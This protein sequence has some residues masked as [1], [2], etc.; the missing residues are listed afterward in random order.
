MTFGIEY[1][2]PGDWDAFCD[3]CKFKRKASELVKEWTGLM[4]CHDTCFEPRHP[5]ELRKQP[6]ENE[7]V[8]WARPV[9]AT[10]DRDPGFTFTPP[11]I[12]E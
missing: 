9:H 7:S 10:A 6:P 1:Y 2:K 11:D 12:P 8:P 5:Q 4:V 3:R